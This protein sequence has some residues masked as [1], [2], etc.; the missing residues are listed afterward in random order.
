MVAH[1]SISEQSAA[2]GW[3]SHTLGK[4][5]RRI[6][7]RFACSEAR[8]RSWRPI[9]VSEV[10]WGSSVSRTCAPNR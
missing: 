6:A 7:H 9:A 8:E 10:T 2:G 1:Y 5:H 3:W 4:L